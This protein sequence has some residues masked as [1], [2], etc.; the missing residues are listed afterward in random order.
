MWGASG[1]MRT[2][3]EAEERL[4]ETQ[5]LCREVTLGHSP[6]QICLLAAHTQLVIAAH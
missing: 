5:P 3:E 4:Q 1:S 6:W 2:Y